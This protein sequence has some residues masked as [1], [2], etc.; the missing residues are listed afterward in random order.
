MRSACYACNDI[1][2]HI[3]CFYHLFRHVGVGFRLPSE[4]DKKG[5]GSTGLLPGLVNI[6]KVGVVTTYG[7]TQ[8]TV[9]LAGE[10]MIVIMN[11]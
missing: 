11:A 7:A 1:Y 4:V 9:T 5:Q 3:L 8:T 10:A 6:E 2:I